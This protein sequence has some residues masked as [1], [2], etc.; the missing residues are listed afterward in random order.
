MAI[1]SATSLK[2][3]S[4]ILM[5]PMPSSTLPRT[6]LSSFSGGSCCRMPTVA[7]VARKASPLFGL[8]KPAMIRK[9]LDLPAPLGPTT[10]ILAPG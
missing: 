5:S 2:R 8:S 7:P 4:L 6:V 10:P 9:T 1:N 3:S